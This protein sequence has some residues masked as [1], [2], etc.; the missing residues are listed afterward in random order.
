MSTL[1]EGS[2]DFDYESIDFDYDRLDAEEIIENMPPVLQEYFKEKIRKEIQD[3]LTQ[4]IAIIYDSNNYKLK[5]ATIVCSF[6]LPLF[7]GKSMSEIA[8]M[9]GVTRQALS[10]SVKQFQ[11]NFN[12]PPTRGQKSL[13][14]CEKYKQ[15]QIERYKNV[16]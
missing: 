11:K 13:A 10:K 4:V 7:L 12:L 3:A 6:G 14:A 2:V 16:H 8:K 1:V 15:A 9:H 5:L